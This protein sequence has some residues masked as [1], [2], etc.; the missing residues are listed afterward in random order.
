MAKLP[1]VSR[2]KRSISATDFLL[3]LFL[4]RLIL[5]GLRVIN[6]RDDLYWEA[7][8]LKVSISLNTLVLAISSI[9]CYLTFAIVFSRSKTVSNV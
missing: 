1:L 2:G 6:V 7:K 5:S 3:R 8:G 4:T 9:A